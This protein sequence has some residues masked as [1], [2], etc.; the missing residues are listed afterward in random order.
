[1]VKSKLNILKKI[2]LM[3]K[4]YNQLKTITD[5][6][7]PG[8]K[9][10]LLLAAMIDQLNQDFANKSEMSEKQTENHFTVFERKTD[11]RFNELE[12]KLD[13]LGNVVNSVSSDVRECPVY[14]QRKS[15]SYLNL[16]INHP[17]LTF[18]LI[19][20]AGYIVGMT[21]PSIIMKL[22]SLLG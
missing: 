6:N 9:K 8:D 13:Q 12:Q 19:L 17:K 22:L 14:S 15:N 18:A 20:L 4:F 11:K 2:R 1:M 3:C 10:L 5:A 7:D 21:G 16:I